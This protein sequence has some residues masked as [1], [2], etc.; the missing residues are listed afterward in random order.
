M[1]QLDLLPQQPE[2]TPAVV[3][4]GQYDIFIV[5][6]SGGK[7]SLACLLH[8][9]SEGVPAHKIEMW[10]HLVDGQEGSTLMDWPCTSA[11]CQAVADAFGIP[12]YFS[13]KEGGFEREMLR[14]NQ[15]TAPIWF[16]V[17]TPAGVVAVKV[18]GE[19]GKQSTRRMFPQV[20]ADLSV[21]WCSAYLKIDV[22]R[23][24]LRNQER[25]HGK[26]VCFVT[27]ERAEESPG[28]AR[29][30]HFERHNA[31]LR[32]GKQYQRHIDQ[33][34]PVHSWKEAEVWE[35]ISCFKVNPHPAYHL[36]WGRVSCRACIFGSDNQ[37]ASLGEVDPDGLLVIAE[38]EEQ[39]GKTIHRTDCVLTRSGRG[40][41]YE[42]AKNSHW[43]KVAMSEAY[44][45]PVIVEEWV[46]PAGAFGESCGPL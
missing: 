21:R 23:V 41:I 40:K 38:H 14:K 5:A 42:E 16:E 36:G 17:P 10:H 31:D 9:I 7:D 3:D 44:N 15:L 11:Y 35:I 6:F 18:G 2:P 4:L 45:E 13:W 32:E 1:G 34:R 37:W 46:L 24:A 20:T 33:L 22:S 19:R 25:L 26:R 30:A 12:L 39:F 43:Q 27:G 8:L 28:R 29:Y